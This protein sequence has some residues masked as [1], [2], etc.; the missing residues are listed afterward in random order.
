MS[1]R[2]AVVDVDGPQPLADLVQ[3]VVGLHLVAGMGD[4]AAEDPDQLARLIEGLARPIGRVMDGD[5]AVSRAL[6]R[7]MW[8]ASGRRLASSSVNRAAS[9]RMR[10]VSRVRSRMVMGPSM[11]LVGT[12]P[13]RLRDVLRRFAAAGVERATA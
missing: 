3:R 6:V 4:V 2:M 11:R 5:P 9:L 10:P 7:S 13:A 12:K 8:S 1:A